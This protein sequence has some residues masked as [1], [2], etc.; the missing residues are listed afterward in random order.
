MRKFIRKILKVLQKENVFEEHGIDSNVYTSDKI[1]KIIKKNNVPYTTLCKDV[2]LDQII[3]HDED[4]DEVPKFYSAKRRSGSRKYKK[5]FFSLSKKSKRFIL[6][7]YLGSEI[8]KKLLYKLEGLKRSE[9]IKTEK[10]IRGNSIK[11]NSKFNSNRSSGESIKEEKLLNKKRNSNCLLETNQNLIHPG[12]AITDNNNIVNDYILSNHI[13][14]NPILKFN[15]TSQKNKSDGNIMKN[16]ENELKDNNNNNSNLNHIIINK[17]H[18]N[19]QQTYPNPEFTMQLLQKLSKISS[20][21][22]CSINRE[23]NYEQNSL[24][25]FNFSGVLSPQILSELY[26]FNS[27]FFQN[28]NYSNNITNF[29]LGNNDSINNSIQE[30]HIGPSNSINNAENQNDENNFIYNFPQGLQYEIN[31]NN[32]MNG[33]S[34]IKNNINNTQNSNSNYVPNSKKSLFKCSTQEMK[35]TQ[36][37][38]SFSIDSD[39]IFQDNNNLNINTLPQS[40]NRS[41]YQ[42]KSVNSLEPDILN[43]DSNI[44]SVLLNKP[45]F[46]N[47]NTNMN[48][49]LCNTFPSVDANQ[50]DNLR[51]IYDMQTYLNMKI[52]AS[53]PSFNIT[54]SNVSG[55]FNN[56]LSTLNPINVNMTSKNNSQMISPI[57]AS[58]TSGLTISPKSAFVKNPNTDME[59]NRNLNNSSSLDNSIKEK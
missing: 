23:N 45:N 12:V 14:T 13:N 53:N 2:I 25:F 6:Y 5:V 16:V 56:N 41:F 52:A 36:R 19:Y 32:L 4:F 54:L 31:I 29:T 10:I 28:I 1:Y 24:N 30:G 51:N 33:P 27:Q 8:R 26:T 3:N 48:N 34:C 9:D 17:D 7:F 21:S 18:F 20:D 59:V 44:S 49:N 15:P 55:N 40:M 38:P 46:A 47:V 22:R 50:F 39:C 58:N 43:D 42:L 11:S 57:K 37:N 35:E